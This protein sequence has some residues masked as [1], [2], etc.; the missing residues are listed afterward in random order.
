M[1]TRRAFSVSVF[2]RCE[3]KILLI[4]HKR[5]QTWLPIGGELSEGETP[6]DA[7]KRE[8]LEET[9]LVGSFSKIDPIE[10]A[11]DGLIGY[12]EHLAGSKGWHLNFVFVADVPT[13]KIKPN[14]EFAEYQ[15]VESTKE[16][17]CPVNVH[18]LFLVA[19]YA[20]ADPLVALAREWLDAFNARDLERLLSLYDDDAVHTSPKLR[21]RHPETKGEVKGKA[22]L[23]AWWSDAMQRLPG[24]RYEEQHLTASDGRVFME[25]LRTVP[26]EPNLLVAE[27]LVCKQG[28]IVS[29][30]VFH[31]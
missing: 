2:A 6:L 9:G 15:W 5:L 21:D 29:S 14:E 20:G 23:R 4:F 31:G 3:G 16:I 25:Y 18:Q 1:S 7:A 19:K 13:Q 24:L 12:E 27:V 30:H 11:P 17:A 28:R 26:G 22:A 10:G 8:L